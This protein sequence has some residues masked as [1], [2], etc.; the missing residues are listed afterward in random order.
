MASNVSDILDDLQRSGFRDLAGA[1]GAAHVPVSRE[2]L[3][4]I[5]AEAVE[6]HRAGRRVE[7]Q[8][9]PGERV[10]VIVTPA[11]GLVPPL[12]IALVVERL[13]GCRGSPLL[14]LRRAFAA[15]LDGSA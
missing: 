8:P 6:G 5:V 9:R 12:A 2:L 7:V 15:W 4:R 13:P 11:G 3:N 10:D 14:V 1:H